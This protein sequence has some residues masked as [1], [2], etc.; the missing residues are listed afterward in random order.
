[1]PTNSNIIRIYWFTSKDTVGIAICKDRVTGEAKGY[2][3]TVPGVDST[4]DT[5]F[6]AEHGARI[7]PQ[8]MREIADLLDSKKESVPAPGTKNLVI[9][10][11]EPIYRSMLAIMGEG[12]DLCGFLAELCK[13]AVV[14]VA[15]HSDELI[16]DFGPEAMANKSEPSQQMVDKVFKKFGIKE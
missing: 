8:I 6:V 7:A 4:L 13:A 3:A 1:M 2:I 14:M 16:K 10:I 9:N 12:F 15:T 5:N 11:E